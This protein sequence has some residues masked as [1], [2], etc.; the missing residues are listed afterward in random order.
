MRV[1]LSKQFT[2]GSLVNLGVLV[3]GLSAFYTKQGAAVD[4]LA[5]RVHS[6]ETGA[7]AYSD[8]LIR[9]EVIQTDLAWIK[10]RIDAGLP[11]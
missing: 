8:L 5:K 6:L 2:V 3:V 10:R 11:K 4:H 1:W 7:K 9:V